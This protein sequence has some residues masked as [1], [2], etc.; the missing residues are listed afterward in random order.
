MLMRSGFSLLWLLAMLFGSG[1]WAGHAA[2]QGLKENLDLP[3]DAIGDSDEEEDAPETVFFYGLTLEGDGF[4]Y[5]IDRSGTMQNMGEL[6][7]AK[8]EVS[9]N[10]SEFSERTQF[11][12][13]FFDA[14]VQ[15]FPSGNQPVEATTSQKQAAQAWVNGM[16][17]GAGTCVQ[18]AFAEALRFANSC[19]AKR[20]V[21]AY[22]SDGGATCGGQNEQDYMKQ[23]LQMLASQNYQ[24]VTINTI[25]VLMTDMGPQ[26]EQFMKD[27]AGQ[28]GGTYRRIN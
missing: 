22:V 25:G 5:I 15:K 23:T 8:R 6:A 14:N 1:A 28:H 3:Y 12:V 19:T 26:H 24:R 17:G 11:A 2:A 10:I 13:I 7:I 18:K 16:Q 9:R 4:F 20:K 27:I 21:I